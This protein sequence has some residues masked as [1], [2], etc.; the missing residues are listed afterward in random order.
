MSSSWVVSL[1]EPVLF[2]GRTWRL[3][4][5]FLA[6]GGTALVTTRRLVFFTHRDAHLIH[7]DASQIT[8]VSPHWRLYYP[9]IV[10]RL[11]DNSD[12]AFSALNPFTFRDAILELTSP[13]RPLLPAILPAGATWPTKPSKAS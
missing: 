10:L 11:I 1:E 6:T 8:A 7:I 13:T 9:K 5:G 4:G 12:L 2:K 3:G